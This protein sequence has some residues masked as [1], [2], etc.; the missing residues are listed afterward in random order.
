LEIASSRIQIAAAEYIGD[1]GTVPACKHSLAEKVA[2]V[3]WLED[4]VGSLMQEF[5]RSNESD[6]DAKR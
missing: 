3:K 5:L 6:L 2:I 1:K 4:N